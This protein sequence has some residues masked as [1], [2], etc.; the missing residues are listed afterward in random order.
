M[1]DRAGAT[2]LIAHE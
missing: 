2:F 1:H